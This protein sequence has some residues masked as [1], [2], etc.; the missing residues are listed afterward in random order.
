[1]ADKTPSRLRSAVLAAGALVVLAATVAG[2]ALPTA[3]AAAAEGAC[4]M[5]LT[6]AL[7]ALDTNSRALDALVE[8]VL[9]Q[10]HQLSVLRDDSMRPANL[11]ECQPT[12]VARLDHLETALAATRYTAHEDVTDTLVAC[13]D[14]YAARVGADIEA[15]RA[16]GDATQVMRLSKVRNRITALVS[17]ST[18]LAQGSR[19]IA[20]KGERMKA[21]V[22]QIRAHCSGGD[23]LNDY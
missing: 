19:S 11:L 1:M 23:L 17:G 16:A 2:I 15:A 3:P 6:A 8:V 10:N 12:L 22:A 21:E 18:S 9:D 13:A 14:H 5:K 20:F 7:E 4:P